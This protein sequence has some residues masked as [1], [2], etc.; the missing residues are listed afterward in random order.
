[1]TESIIDNIFF[2]FIL[3]I[4]FKNTSNYLAIE[5]KESEGIREENQTEH[6]KYSQHMIFFLTV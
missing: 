3:I 5:F 4:W 6:A 1:M 2:N